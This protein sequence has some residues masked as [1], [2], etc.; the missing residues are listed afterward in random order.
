MEKAV[1][2]DYFRQR[3]KGVA[4]HFSLF[5]QNKNPEELHQMRVE[6]KK[7][8]A[9]LKLQKFKENDSQKLKYFRPVRNIF[10]QAGLIREAQINLQILQSIP[11]QDEKLKLFLQETIENETKKFLIKAHDFSSQSEK[12]GVKILKNIKAL[13][14]KKVHTFCRMHLK[15]ISKNFQRKLYIS[16]LH[17]SRKSI[18]ALIH[19]HEILPN[20]GFDELQINWSYLFEF[21]EKI[22]NWHDLHRTEFWMKKNRVN[23]SSLKIIHAKLQE[24]LAEIRELKKG[25]EIKTLGLNGNRA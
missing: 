13:P 18:K 20:E 15:L 25:F 7:A 3:I 4:D 8:Y 19:L 23:K 1:Q 17:E 12:N 2:K 9:L 11:V 10:K 6:I 22:G 16:H 5:V 24:Q 14:V 21:Q